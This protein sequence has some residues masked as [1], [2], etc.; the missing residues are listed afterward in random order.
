MR[1]RFDCIPL[2]SFLLSFQEIRFH[3]ELPQDRPIVVRVK[4]VGFL[5][6]HPSDEQ[7]CYRSYTDKVR[8]FSLCYLPLPS[9]HDIRIQSRKRVDSG[10]LH[11]A[12]CGLVDH[13]TSTQASYSLL[14]RGETSLPR[15]LISRR[16]MQSDQMKIVFTDIWTM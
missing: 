14:S 2:Q 8:P 7:Q 1:T 13:Q 10:L 4:H 12:A 15:N 5:D 3:Y 9:V 16:K 11:P 6:H